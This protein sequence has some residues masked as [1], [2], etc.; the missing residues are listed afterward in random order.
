MLETIPQITNR[1]LEGKTL[2][3]FADALGIGAPRQSVSQ[4]A[5]GT[6][7]PSPRKLWDVIQSPMA[8]P[9]AKEWAR[10]CLKSLQGGRE[11]E[12]TLEDEV[13]RRR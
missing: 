5:L 8:E 13:E 6:H 10:E 12:D 3:Q 11:V 1:Y 4:W 7:E 2:Q 9:W